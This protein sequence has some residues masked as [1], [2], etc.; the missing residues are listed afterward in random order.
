[1]RFRCKILAT[2]L[3]HSELQVLL[4]WRND[5][6]LWICCEDCLK[7]RSVQKW[8]LWNQ[9]WGAWFDL[10]WRS[11]PLILG[12][13]KFLSSLDFHGSS[14]WLGMTEM[15]ECWEWRIKSYYLWKVARPNDYIGSIQSA[16][17]P[18]CGNLFYYTKCWV[19]SVFLFLV[20]FCL[21]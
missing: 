6:Y 18:E 19:V 15:G 14:L 17:V 16:I 5:A 7:T 9:R 4:K 8:D 21:F 13:S 3:S 12:S 20:S 11:A 1:M 2:S 10:S